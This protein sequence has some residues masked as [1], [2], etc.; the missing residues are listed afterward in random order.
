MYKTFTSIVTQGFY[1][2]DKIVNYFDFEHQH[3][4]GRLSGQW[5]GL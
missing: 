3:P 2:G 5:L 4:R 1:G